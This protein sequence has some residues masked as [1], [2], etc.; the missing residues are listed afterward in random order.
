MGS[1][2]LIECVKSRPI[3]YQSAKKMYKDSVMKDAQWQEI[4]EELGEDVT[5]MSISFSRPDHSARPDS[6]KGRYD[7]FSDP[8]HLNSAGSRVF[9][10]FLPVLNIFS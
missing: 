1:E 7:H 10:Q 8:T 9:C 5:G 4:A 6:L 3:L 2:K